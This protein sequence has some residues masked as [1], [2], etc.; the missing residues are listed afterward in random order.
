MFLENREHS[1]SHWVHKPVL[2]EE[3]K[4]ALAWGGSSVSFWDATVGLAGHSRAL[5]LSNKLPIRYVATDQDAVAL[6]QA[7]KTLEESFGSSW[8]GVFEHSNFADYAEQTSDRFDRILVDLG[9]SSYQLDDA[10]RGFSFQKEG[11]L[12]MRM[13]PS[14][15]RALAD[16]LFHCDRDEF[17]RVLRM[18][19]VLQAHRLVDRW[20]RERDALVN[21][22]GMDTE[23]R[24]LMTTKHFVEALGHRL[25]SKDRKG[26]HPLTLV[27]QALR[28]FINC[29]DTVLER[30][31]TRLPQILAPEGRVAIISFH[32]Q[33]D[34][35]VKWMLKETLE[36]ITKK[37]VMASEAE[38]QENPRARS[39]KLRVYR[40]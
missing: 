28:V 17:L 29:E 5:L 10:T 14:K 20:L 9:V 18:G 21:L 27:F 19:E 8:V 38:A 16:W 34:R 2:V 11:P 3:I 32:S 13:D 6:E 40:S 31:L 24:P 25:D 35:M 26:R 36:P 30:L 22:K 1:A 37:V 39:A 12:D 23:G 4:D 15:G 7:K 33:E